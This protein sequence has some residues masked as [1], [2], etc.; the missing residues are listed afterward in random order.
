MKKWLWIFL[1]TVGLTA[2]YVGRTIIYNFADVNDYKKFPQ[3]PVLHDKSPFT[4]YKGKTLHLDTSFLNKSYITD[5]KI[6]DLESLFKRTKTTAFLIIR[7]DS[8]LYERYFY[9]YDSSSLFT[10]F[11]MAKSL[12][13]LL[14]GIAWGE[15]KIASLDDPI[16]KYVPYLRP[17]LQ[18]VT[19]QH[20]LDMESGIKFNENFY[21]PFSQ[22]AKYYYGRHLKKFVRELSLG[23]DPGTEFEYRNVNTL[24]LSLALENVTGMKTFKYLEQKLWSQ[25]GTEHDATVNIDSKKDSTFKAYTGFNATARDYAKVGRLLLHHG[26]CHGKQVIPEPYVEKLLNPGTAKQVQKSLYYYK[27]HWWYDSY[28]NIAAHGF[29]GQFVVVYP[30]K[31]IIMVRLGKMNG[32]VEWVQLMTS[33]VKRL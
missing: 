18:K 10:S 30:R 33:M 19:L 25:I 7:N 2:C 4:F 29:L 23:K 31:N 5:D 28:G 16:T 17:E 13:S 15:G 9:G 24:L 6:T 22:T 26:K 11:S 20:L 12:V 27:N 8:I 14:V 21:N 3:V 1:L 32:G